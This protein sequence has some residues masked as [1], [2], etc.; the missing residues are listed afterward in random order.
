MN[1]KISRRDMFKFIGGSAV[2]IML[3]PIPWKL[4]D[5]SAIWTQNWSWIPEPLKGKFQTRF[6]TCTLCPAGCA[7]RVR[8][9]G[10]QPVSLSGVA[11]HPISHG[12]LCPVGLGAHHLPYHPARVLQPFKRN[13]TGSSP[14]SLDEAVAA[15]AGTIATMKSSTQNESIAVL[16]G[17]PGRTMSLLYRRFLSEV[18]NGVYLTT[19]RSSFPVL[20]EMFEKSSAAFGYD[21]ENAKTI[22][23][24]G[25]PI[26]DGWGTPGRVMAAFNRKRERTEKGFHLIQ[27]ETRYSRTAA[28]A[29]SW[30]PINPGTEL[31]FALGLANVIIAEKLYDREKIHRLAIDFTDFQHFV[32]YFTPDVAERITGVH[33]GTIAG[34]AREIAQQKPSLVVG[35]GNPGGGPLGREEEI[36]IWGLNFLIGSVG[37]AGG[38]VTRREIPGDVTLAGVKPIQETSIENAA[39]NSIRLLIIDEAESGNALPSKLIEKKLVREGAVVVS[40]SPFLA[41]YAAKAK[42]IIP[43][44]TFLESRRDV[45]TP[46]DATVASLSLSA[47]LVERPGGVTEP[48]D[49][50]QRLASAAGISLGDDPT[51]KTLEPFIK[52]RIGSIHKSK[53]GSVFTNSDKNFVEVKNIPSPDDLWKMLSEGGCWM[54]KAYETASLPR[55]SFFG[56]IPGDARQLRDA[57]EGKLDVQDQSRMI[58]DSARE[59]PLVLMPYGWRCASGTAQLSPIMTKVYQESNLRHTSR[60]ALLNP[61][62]AKA[63]GLS[64]GTLMLIETKSG[65]AKIEARFNASVMPGVIQVEVGPD[66]RAFSAGPTS[67]ED[68]LSLCTIKEN[69]TWRITQAKARRA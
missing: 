20:H 15:I 24:F 1:Q 62:T 26:L 50:L 65:S 49:F 35:D 46:P 17:Q 28:L 61:I 23:S 64:D 8:C 55:F 45:A 2:G 33:A 38:V 57:V 11:S 32:K 30:I 27:I 3:T 51:A 59:Y 14:I 5:D 53:R 68:I 4:L 39:D 66:V 36:A 31:P 58:E 7:V 13:E 41:G 34:T 40:L 25:A 43:S 69:S 67:G 42:Y 21:V 52:Q 12:A 10:D 44:P 9:V 54:D 19:G 6:T 16:D 56:K 47:P 48:V 60:Q 18:P 63:Y 29:D 37:R 22:V